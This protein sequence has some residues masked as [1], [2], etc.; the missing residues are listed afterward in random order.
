MAP[1]IVKR[2]SIA[3]GKYKVAGFGVFALAV[4]VAGLMGL[5]EPP[6]PTYKATGVMSSN[7]QPVILSETGPAIQEQGRQ[8][9]TQDYL[10]DDATAEA[11]SEQIGVPPRK[12]K[13]AQLRTPASD[14][15]Q[16]YRV[17]YTDSTPE[18]ASIVVNLLMEAAVEK[19]Y[20]LNTSR[21]QALIDA[22]NER[23]PEIQQELREAEDR[24]VR[25]DRIE[26]AAITLAKDGSLV[27][28]IRASQQQQEQLRL[29]VEEMAAQMDS[30]EQ[31]LG[32][33]VTQAYVS[34]ALSRD[35]ILNNLRAQLYQVETQ[36]ALLGQTLRP[37][38][39]QMVELQRQFDG[40]ERLFVQRAVEVIGGEGIATPLSNSRAIRQASSLDP[41]RQEMAARLVQLQTERDILDR[42]LAQAGR[43]E[44][45]LKA[46]YA[47]LPD[48][49]LERQRLQ[50]EVLLH[51]A[52]S[53]QLQAQL[54]DAE[55][56][57]A[58]T[59][60]NLTIA[61]EAQVVEQKE[62]PPNVAILVLLGGGVG[63]A[64][65]GALIFLLSALEGR[66]Y[67]VEEVRGALQERDLLLLG[68]LPHVVTEE[69]GDESKMP[70]IVAPDSPYLEHYERFRSNLRRVEGGAPK[71]VLIT[72]A[73]A[74]E[75]K[76]FTAYNL[77]IASA[78]AGKRTLLVEA[79]L[80]S[81]SKA[82]SLKVALD[83][84]SLIEPLRHYR[85]FQSGMRFV[86]QVENLYT[87]PSPGPQQHAAA[88]IESSELR[89][90]LSQAR[91][92]FDFVVVD[93][94]SLSQ[95][96]D[97]LLLEPYT[98]GMILVARPGV[99]EGGLLAEYAEMLEEAEDRV[100]VLGAVIDDAEI[101]VEFPP[102][103]SPE[104]ETEVTDS[105]MPFYELWE[106]DRLEDEEVS[107]GAT[108][109]SSV[110]QDV[111]SRRS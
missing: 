104:D 41:M 86:P 59:V 101:P 107:N 20:L 7:E 55:A 89:R 12:V 37:Q 108:S 67:T 82:E 26:G 33:N 25:F 84:H 27:G 21:L 23:L 71:V 105:P 96:N 65:G 85:D 31:Q 64:A 74:G 18:R 90:L 68:T 36:Q 32:L 97:A 4:G 94:P 11:V 80:R 54:V 53:D 100:R 40:L 24:L 66:F 51:K 95:C 44:R 57:K 63:L 81:P 2:Y 43:L 34:S 111:P 98:D 103:V 102:H 46:T 92:Q 50:Q 19:S 30:L 13:S 99:T 73:K 29:Q 15:P 47:N 91:V 3:F 28:Q 87:I 45:E 49:E 48:L 16:F 69:F 75:G 60:S 10:I 52:L 88:I 62:D 77:A 17:A 9:L 93:A 106:T 72:S 39:P 8:A 110:S 58:E 61:Q 70:V 5:Q 22:L 76:T 79:D 38:H 78:R 14:E 35:P 42:S 56:A 83:P 1:S 109:R 6:P